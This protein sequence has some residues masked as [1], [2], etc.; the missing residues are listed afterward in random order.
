M[1]ARVGS[2]P[3]FRPSGAWYKLVGSPRDPGIAA[4]SFAM[5]I[6]PKK[7][8]KMPMPYP[9]YETSVSAAPRELRVRAERAGRPPQPWSWAIY[10]LGGGEPVFRSTRFY[11]SAGPC[12]IDAA[13]GASVS[14]GP[15]VQAM[16]TYS[17]RPRSNMRFSTSAAMATSVVWRPS[18][19]ERRPSP[20]TRFQRD[21]SASIRARQL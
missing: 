6:R 5:E 19:C 2:S 18:V 9:T 10:D 13:L 8:R 15:E 12:C 16:R 17:G 3:R 20:M 7:Q 14:K 21:T 4:P 11:R 1:S